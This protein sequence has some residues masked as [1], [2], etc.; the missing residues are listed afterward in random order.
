[1]K[2]HI[3]FKE[4]KISVV[5]FLEKEMRK[6][7]TFTQLDIELFEQAKVIEEDGKHAYYLYGHKVGFTK[8]KE[9]EICKCGQP[10]VGGYSCQRT[11]CN[12]N[13]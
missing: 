6:R 8:A 3:N 2:E 7:H 4:E 12:Q 5:E 13:L 9:Q 11:D 10:K 1:M